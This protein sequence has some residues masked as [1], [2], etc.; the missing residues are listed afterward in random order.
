MTELAKNHGRSYPIEEPVEMPEGPDIGRRRGL[1]ALLALIATGGCSSSTPTQ[2][3]Y[4]DYAYGHQ[5][6]HRSPYRRY[7]RR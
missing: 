6:F 7:P 4:D 3:P 2:V 1:L 5:H